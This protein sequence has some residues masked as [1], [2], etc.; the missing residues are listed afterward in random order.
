M[1]K[2]SFAVKKDRKVL[3]HR[4]MNLVINQNLQAVNLHHVHQVVIH[5]NLQV[6]HN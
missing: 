1:I 5:T 6:N 4:M 3:I 2:I